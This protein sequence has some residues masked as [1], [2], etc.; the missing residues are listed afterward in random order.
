VAGDGAQKPVAARGL[1]GGGGGAGRV[2]VRREVTWGAG[3]YEGRGCA[4]GVLRG[5]GQQTREGARRRR[6]WVQPVAC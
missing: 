2:S 5:G 6:W 3:A 4:A 1:G